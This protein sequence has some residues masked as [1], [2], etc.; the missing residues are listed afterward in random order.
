M[1]GKQFFGLKIK[2][3]SMLPDYKDGDVVIFQKQP[4]CNNGDDC[5]VM[6]NGNDATFKRVFKNDNGIL[7]QPLN[8]SVCEPT[9]YNNEEIETLPVKIIGVYEELRRKRK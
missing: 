3:D 5:V 6:V 4:D 1:N 8:P 2:G 7:L 9:S